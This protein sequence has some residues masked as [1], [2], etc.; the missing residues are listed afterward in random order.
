MESVKQYSRRL[1]S[2]I[3][4]RGVR[5]VYLVS[6]D[7]FAVAGLDPWPTDPEAVAAASAV[8]AVSCSGVGRSLALGALKF[9]LLEYRHGAIVIAPRDEG[10]WVVVADRHLVVGEIRLRLGGD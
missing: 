6:Q 7:G 1:E 3:E 4:V 8:T 2:L 5:G 10:I 9:I